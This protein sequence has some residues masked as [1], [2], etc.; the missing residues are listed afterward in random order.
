MRVFAKSMLAVFAAVIFLTSCG[1]AGTN[2]V[3][4]CLKLSVDGLKEMKAANFDKAKMEEIGKKYKEKGAECEKMAEGKSDE[5]KKKME[6]EAKAC[7]AY[8]EMEALSK[9]MME[10][11]M[12]N[13]GEQL[14]PEAPETT[15]EEP[16]TEEETTEEKT[17]EHGEQH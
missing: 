8:K 17:E 6:E 10:A 7:P 12:K 1:G 13:V 11:V 15:E 2:S 9:E 5:D 16:A 3:C 14:A 4:G